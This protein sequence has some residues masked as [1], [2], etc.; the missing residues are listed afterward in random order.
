MTNGTN[1][2][3]PPGPR[4]F[5]LGRSVLRRSRSVTNRALDTRLV[6]TQ[7]LAERL[8]KL[9][10]LHA[11]ALGHEDFLDEALVNCR[12]MAGFVVA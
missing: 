8:G 5:G 12:R 11:A 10:S 3:R 9:V 2:S 6:L 7:Q 1:V 4:D